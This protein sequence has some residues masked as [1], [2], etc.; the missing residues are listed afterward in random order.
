MICRHVAWPNGSEAWVVSS[1]VYQV[2]SYHEFL[3]M[4]LAAGSRF[5]A[6]LRLA[7]LWR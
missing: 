5:D 3:T 7:F 1:G 2:L 4:R 6:L